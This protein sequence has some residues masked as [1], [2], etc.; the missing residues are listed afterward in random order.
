MELKLDLAWADSNEVVKLA[1]QDAGSYTLRSKVNS[2]AGRYDIALEDTRRA[3]QLAPDPRACYARGLA[4]ASST[5]SGRDR[6]PR[7]GDRT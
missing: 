3:I 4:Y 6:G 7:Q 1:P 2:L 5:T